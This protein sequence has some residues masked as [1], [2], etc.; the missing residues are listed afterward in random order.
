MTPEEIQ[1]FYMVIGRYITD[2]SF[3]SL[4][5][6]QSQSR[7]EGVDQSGKGFRVFGNTRL[8]ALELIRQCLQTLSHSKYSQLTQQ[9]ISP[10]LKKHLLQGMLHIIKEYWH[11]DLAHMQAV[12]VLTSLG[13]GFD[14]GDIQ[15]LKT[16][17][18][19]FLENDE[20]SKVRYPESGRQTSSVPTAVIVKICA[21]LKKMINGES[22][23][24]DI[25][26]Q[27]HAAAHHEE[28][29]FKDKEEEK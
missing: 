24:H 13:R 6:I 7:E 3:S 27:S 5:V 1:D 25:E 8:R 26:E 28:D 10:I 22:L 16:F 29:F 18:K 11:C 2:I 15:V 4:M 14:E 21:A 17:V 19:S 9:A 23:L 20:E 12:Q